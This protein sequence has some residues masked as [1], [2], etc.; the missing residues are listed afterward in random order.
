[1]LRQ[2]VCF[3]WSY[4]LEQKGWGT[5]NYNMQYNETVCIHVFMCAR[6]LKGD[7]DR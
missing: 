1:M 4:I 5:F 3:T 2:F 6:S 7:I